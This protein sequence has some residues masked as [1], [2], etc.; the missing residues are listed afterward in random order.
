MESFGASSSGPGTYSCA[1]TDRGT[2]ITTKTVAKTTEPVFIEADDKAEHRV[3]K[4]RSSI[5]PLSAGDYVLRDRER[6]REARP[7]PL[8]SKT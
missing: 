4:G 2:K 5:L 8:S 3:K 7:A 1:D 6:S